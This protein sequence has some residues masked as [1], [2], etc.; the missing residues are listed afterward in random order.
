MPLHI[1]VTTVEYL[2]VEVIASVV[3]EAQALDSQE[4][5]PL[6]AEIL[7][8]RALALGVTPTQVAASAIEVIPIQVAALAIGITPIQLHAVIIIPT[9]TMEVAVVASLVAEALAVEAHAVAVASL[10]A[11]AEALAEA[12]HA[13]VAASAVAA[14]EDDIK[15]VVIKKKHSTKKI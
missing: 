12:A 8:V 1:H 4:E 9:L 15:A 5:V 2:M 10:A 6:S 7:L 11:E 13:V 3:V 14:E